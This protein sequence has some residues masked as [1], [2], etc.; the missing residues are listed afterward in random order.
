MT[1]WA[2]V[3]KSCTLMYCAHFGG[4]QPTKTL[5]SSEIKRLAKMLQGI[6]ISQSQRG[7]VPKTVLWSTQERSFEKK[8]VSFPTPSSHHTSRLL[9]LFFFLSLLYFFYSLSLSLLA[10]CWLIVF[11]FLFFLHC[12][13]LGV[14]M[15]SAAFRV[16]GRD[17]NKSVYLSIYQQPVCQKY[18]IRFCWAAQVIAGE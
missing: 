17:A 8:R 13:L 2:R 4:K 6:W 14:I 9:S 11:V 3:A 1:G 15:N 10:A 12:S 18:D 16:K 7:G 5:K